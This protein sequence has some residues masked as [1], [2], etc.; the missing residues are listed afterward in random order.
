MKY[1]SLFFFM[2]FGLFVYIFIPSF[3]K[4][5]LQKLWFREFYNVKRRLLLEITTMGLKAECWSNHTFKLNGS[6]VDNKS[7]SK[8]FLW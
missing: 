7:L 8:N 1:S 2:T 6:K 3:T 5:L 4:G